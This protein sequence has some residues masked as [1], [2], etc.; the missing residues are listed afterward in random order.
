MVNLALAEADQLPISPPT[1]GSIFDTFAGFIA[2]LSVQVGG[3]SKEMRKQRD[4]R[5]ALL[6]AIYPAAIPPR[7]VQVGASGALTIADAQ[8]LGPVTGMLWDVRRISVFGLAS[9]SE[10]VDIYKVSGAASSQGVVAQ[11]YVATITGPRGAYSPGLGAFMLRHH[12]SIVV[13]GTGLTNNEWVTV[14]ADAINITE[15]WLGAYL[16]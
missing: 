11:N 6:Q 10:S 13:S 8:Q 9:S 14:S 15:A 3:L 7:S 1:T 5:Y 2:E 4:E 12:E 16:L